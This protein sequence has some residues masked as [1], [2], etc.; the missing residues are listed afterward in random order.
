MFPEVG[1]CIIVRGVDLIVKKSTTFAARHGSCA[2]I[3]VA[4]FR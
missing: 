1:V 4:S 2:A 3:E